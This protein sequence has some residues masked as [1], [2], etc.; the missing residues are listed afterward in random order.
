VNGRPEPRGALLHR[1]EPELI[2]TLPHLPLSERPTPVRRLWGLDQRGDGQAQVWVK[3]DGAY[4]AGGWGGNKVRKLEWILPEVKRRG[5][6]TI[7]TVGGLGTNWGLAVALYGRDQG[8]RTALALVDQPKDEHVRAQLERLRRS[9]ARLY[10][11]HTRA[12]TLAAA[13]LLMARHFDGLTP[14]HFLPP[15]GSNATGALGYVE[16]G[17]EIAEQVS[18]GDLPE[19]SHAVVAVG[20]GG[21]A[22]GLALGLRM[23]GLRTRLVGVVVNDK[24]RLDEPALEKLAW[25]TAGLLRTRGARMRVGSASADL[26]IE[27]VPDWIG[28]GYGHPTAESETALELL[29][30]SDD[31][32][33]DPVYTAKAMA[34]LIAMNEAGRFGDGPVLYIH[35]DG[36]R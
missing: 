1:L 25:R 22:A 29:A 4:G 36:P 34:G 3:D 17:L 21:T 24:L 2:G 31:V 20:S 23:A 5:S 18:R 28:P 16:A 14:P 7:L 30:E 19:P 11:T 15:G 9:G 13:P 27:S 26:T 12:R 10:F 8:L 35:T 33:L 32:H 6:R